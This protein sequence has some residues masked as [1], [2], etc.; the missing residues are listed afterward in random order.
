MM[1]MNITQKMKRIK[2]KLRI[3][4]NSNLYLFIF[5]LKSFLILAIDKIKEKKKN[6]ELII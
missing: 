5:N 4:K 3:K 2:K 6:L 1:N